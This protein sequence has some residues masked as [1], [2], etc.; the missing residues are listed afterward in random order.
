MQRLGS[1]AVRSLRYATVM[2]V[3]KRRFHNRGKWSYSEQE[4]AGAIRHQPIK[5]PP[6]LV[7]GYSVDYSTTT[8]TSTSTEVVMPA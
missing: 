2:R 6:D 1:S 7:R 5:R 4:R 3:G 8:S